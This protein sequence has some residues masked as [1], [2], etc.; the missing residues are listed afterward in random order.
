MRH[1]LITGGLGFIGSHLVES[2]LADGDCVTVLDSAPFPDGWAE[3]Y[4]DNAL[5]IHADIRDEHALD[6]LDPVDVIVHLAAL[7]G[8]RSSID[9]PFTYEDVNVKGT[10]TMLEFAKRAR[11]E[12]FVF[13]SSSSVYGNPDIV[14]PSSEADAT[15]PISPYGLTKLTGEHFCRI[16][17]QVYGLR[18]I[19][20]RFFTVYGPRQRGDLAIQK[21]AR[22][23]L[24]GQPVPVYGDGSTRRDYTFIDDTVAGIKAA[25]DYRSS[26]F[27]AVNLGAGRTVT[28]GDMVEELAR[29]LGVEPTIGTLPEQPGDVNFT[30]ADGSKARMLLGFEPRV[31]FAHGIARFAEWLR[32][33]VAAA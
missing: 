22:R 4:G 15:V 8:V 6:H 26:M 30:W 21:F 9:Q 18:S 16:Y 10:L 33:E 7:A 1:V 31:T 20:L 24:S 28:L 11:V 14:Q 23:M 12:Q 5:G 19:A 27:E 25:M 29:A 13:A 17:A 2:V 32:A 3:R